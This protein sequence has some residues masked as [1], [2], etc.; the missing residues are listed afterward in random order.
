MFTALSRK[1]AIAW[2][3]LAFAG[4]VTFA[5]SAKQDESRLMRFN[6]RGTPWNEVLETFAT[7]AGLSLVLDSPPLGTLNYYTD[8]RQFTPAESI[9]LLNSVLMTK[10]YTLIRRE[11]ML[12][13]INVEDDGVPPDL[14]TTISV[15]QLDERGNFE[16]VRCVFPIEN[17]T[18]EEAEAEAAKFVGRLGSIE[19]LPRSKQ[20]LVTEMG[21]R[22]RSIRDV[23]QRIAN[24]SE[25]AALK[26]FSLNHVTAENAIAIIRQMFGLSEEE[27]SREDGS[28]RVAAGPAGS[29]I[30]SAKAA[31]LKEVED[32]VKMIDSPRDGSK[33]ILDTPQ[34]EIYQV[35]GADPQSVLQVN[36]TLFADDKEIRLA[37]DPQTGS[38]I[39]WATPR[40]HRTIQAVLAQMQKDGRRS[41]VIPLHSIDPAFAV[42]AVN[43]LF[44][45]TTE[46]VKIGPRVQADA[47]TGNLVVR[48]T[49]DQI[50]E[51]RSLLNQMS[52]A[53]KVLGASANGKV[54]MISVSG[55]EAAWILEQAKLIWPS[56]RG[57]AIRPAMLDGKSLA[58][59]PVVERKIHESDEEGKADSATK[60]KKTNQTP[61]NDNAIRSTKDGAST[62][63]RAAEL[64]FLRSTI[65]SPLLFDAPVDPHR[66][67]TED[68]WAAAKPE[69][70]LAQLSEKQAL[71]RL[72]K[73]VVES[74]I[75][76]PVNSAPDR[77]LP[78]IFFAPGPK[79]LLIGSDDL[80]ALDAFEELLLSLIEENAAAEKRYTVYYLKHEDANRAASLLGEILGLEDT[81][82]GESGGGGGLLGNL[83]GA[84]LGDS[85]G[86]L[87]GSLLGG[88]SEASSGGRSTTGSISIV[89][90]L[91]L[92]LLVIHARPMDLDLVEQ[93]LL[94][95]D[96]KRSKEDVETKPMAR[97]IQVFNTN[98]EEIAENIKQLYSDRIVGNQSQPQQPRPEDIIR[99]MRGGGRG[100]RREKDEENKQSITISVDVRNNRLMVAAPDPL[101]EQIAQVVKELDQISESNAETSQVISLKRANPVLVHDAL[102][103]IIGSQA[104]ESSTATSDAQK[105][106]KPASG[107]RQ[108]SRE[109]TSR[110]NSPGD[111]FQFFRALQESRNA[112]RFGKS[113]KKLTK[114][115]RNSEK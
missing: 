72:N 109:N 49:K 113:P 17:A 110:V 19:V 34:L 28:L 78:E 73:A 14:L 111:P 13:V 11:K 115:A 31:E 81:G 97:P 6:F 56:I 103:K 32:V 95:I 77:K 76:A 64:S 102:Q 39:A 79:G 75:S 47:E 85:G 38:L 88:M 96:Q 98:A 80:E 92:N 22:L 60:K 58:P 101:F 106:T 40:Q 83:A 59:K 7:K 36:Q 46:G 94:V 18:P 2:L 50:D 63:W 37:T 16:L 68:E 25:K 70:L 30:V 91:R 52:E 43:E 10:G 24:P 23:L 62:L 114:G 41:E 45:S 61:E 5:Q 104:M 93:L 4:Q 108:G 1:L 89:P 33:N 12:M 48:G 53:E 90:N 42:T 99:A 71:D 26:D 54:R 69:T 29:L 44:G 9:D 100:S 66:L 55:R 35:S 51:I 15:D 112:D 82:G 20:L 21:G 27:N 86:G 3:F 8:E 107:A 74:E 57:N 105:T 84:A 87:M 67:E 65:A